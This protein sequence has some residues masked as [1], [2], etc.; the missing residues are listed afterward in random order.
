MVFLVSRGL[1]PCEARELAQEVWI[2][3]MQQQRDERL[4][5][6]E[7]PGLA[8]A[9]ARF[10]HLDRMRQER[11]L[12][13][14]D[15]V[16]GLPDPAAAER[17]LDRVRLGRALAA[18]DRCSERDRALFEA[19]YAEQAPSQRVLANT[20]GLSLQRTKQILCSV[21]ATLRRALED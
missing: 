3:L 4:S 20:F 11:V 14:L 18:L 8:L 12:V 21:R 5:R 6:I 10:L 19:A 17:P 15:A 2:R 7:L 13:P 1:R 9:Q 16:R